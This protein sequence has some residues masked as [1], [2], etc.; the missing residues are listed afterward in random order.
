MT[1]SVARKNRQLPRVS[2]NVIGR[3]RLTAA[4]ETDKPLTLLRAAS[5]S[6]KTTALVGWAFLT[7]ARVVWLTVTPAH[8][9]SADLARALLRALHTQAPADAPADD[10]A[11]DTPALLWAAVAE[12][13][14]AT[15]EP[16]A[17]VL[18]DAAALDRDTVF[19]L[20][21]TVAAAPLARLVAAT[22][23]PSPFDSSGLDLL[24]DT[25]VLGPH[26]LM[27]DR[28]EIRAALDLDDDD[29]VTAILEATGGF[30]GAV[31]A[32]ALRGGG[33]G[34]PSLVEAASATIEDYLQ[35]RIEQGDFAE[36]TLDDLVRLSITD[37]VDAPLAVAL[38]GN[39]DVVRALDEAEVFGFGRWEDGEPR[40]FRL[41]PLARTLLHR[42]LRR[43]HPTEIPQLRRLAVEG[44]VLRGAPFEGLRL[45]VE[46]GDLHFASHVIMSGWSH[47]LDHDGR[48]VVR[49]LGDLPLARLKQEPLVAM[50]LGICLNANR[51]RRLRGLQL[52]RVAVSAANARKNRLSAIERIFIWTAESAALRVIGLPDR[53]GQVAARALALLT[54]TPETQWERY[55]REMPL[56]CTHLA[57]SLHYGGRREQAL[58]LLDEAA[59]LAASQGTRNAFHAVSLLAGIHALNGDLPE[60]RHYVDLIRDGGWSQD[61][62]DGYRGTFYRVAEAMLAVE[63]GDLH[64]A[65]QHVRAFLPHRAT[66][67]HWT[68]MASVEAWIALHEGDA[69]GGLERLESFA[70]MRGREAG[71]PHARTTLSR[72]RILLHLALGD[73]RAARSIKQ[74]DAPG[75]RFATLLER[76]RV[77]LVDG[78][79]PD[80]VR[81]LTQTRLEPTTS[82]ERAEAAAVQSAALHRVTPAAAQRATDALG[83]Q[84]ADRELRTPIALLG[85]EDFAAVRADLAPL[86]G[87]PLP[88]R[89]ALPSFATRPRLSSREQVVLHALTSGAPLPEIAAELSVSQNTLKTQLRSIYRKLDAGNR[90]EALEQAARHGLLPD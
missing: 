35:A 89:S 36:R 71:S 90:T 2:T 9:R 74:R 29:T 37:A 6:G 38:T 82:R 3:P 65:K 16:L 41:A 70:R 77:A 59:A 13:L 64:A 25:V 85:A 40:T 62:L 81:L 44:A 48:A 61:E 5:G 43:T 52:L 57:L 73:V 67:E 1:D 17:I 66:S 46:E 27:F 15:T 47:L 51:L 14:C 79:A 42:E 72:P 86:P 75:D 22:N 60:A 7:A 53:G 4:I 28:D 87:A 12:H 50:L 69:A 49:L 54:E 33:T 34:G 32:A 10:P 63:D 83:A 80:A 20:C 55:A 8:Q 18:D 11:S 21:R 24:I 76:A 58:G 30:P 78:R 31:R 23:R 19:D 68:T 88:L 84:L 45:A 26:D 39:P 56:V